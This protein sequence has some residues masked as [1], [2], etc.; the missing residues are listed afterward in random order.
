MLGDNT[1][2]D[3]DIVSILFED[4][5][6]HISDGL[7]SPAV[8]QALTYT[9]NYTNVGNSLAS[10]V[11][12]TATLSPGLDLTGAGWF[13]AGGGRF[14]HNVGS[15]GAGGANSVFL[16]AQVDPGVAANTYISNSVFIDFAG[17][18]AF[19]GNNTDSDIDFI[20]PPIMLFQID[21]GVAAVAP[22]QTLSYAFQY[23]NA[24]SVTATNII[25][26]ETL[27]SASVTVADANGWTPSGS[28]Y[29]RAVPDL[30]PGSSASVAFGLKVLDNAAAGDLI[31]N[32]GR[33]R[34]GNQTPAADSISTDTDIVASGPAP[35]LQLTAYA[36]SNVNFGTT[37]SA[38]VTVTNAGPGPVGTWFSVEIYLDRMPQTRTDLGDDHQEIGA[39]RSG[40]QQT[41]VF[42]LVELTPGTHAVYFQVDTCYLAD[43]IWCTNASY[44][45]IAESNE[46]NN[47]F[48]PLN[49]VV[50]AP[51]VPP[52]QLFL[53]IISR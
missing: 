51:N 6:V 52:Y 30:G 23:H 41:R 3:I 37:L 4:L 31:T 13:S 12:L 11:V 18:D 1:A 16:H 39:M 46:A 33:L 27:P 32:T 44:G 25:L 9:I 26:T 38:V 48:G 34:A 2:T 10:G 45:R 15:M 29:V 17:L 5:Q 36:P 22:G 47:V 19:P 7:S 24:G 40:E 42:N 20:S 35:D 14:T 28:S 8:G 21:D 49:V 53:P 43:P 50:L